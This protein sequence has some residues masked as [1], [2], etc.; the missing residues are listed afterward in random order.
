MEFLR[1][2]SFSL[3]SVMLLFVVWIHAPAL[4]LENYGSVKHLRA[5][6]R[7]SEGQLVVT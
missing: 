1:V 7:I 3:L 5:M 6:S 2:G 4:K